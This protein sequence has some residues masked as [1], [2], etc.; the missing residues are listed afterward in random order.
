M[1]K[2]RSKIAVLAVVGMT[3]GVLPGVA[4]ENAFDGQCG[5]TGDGIDGSPWLLA[6]ES[7]LIQIEDCLVV[8]RTN[9]FELSQNIFIGSGYSNINRDSYLDDSDEDVHLDGK[10]YGIYG[11]KLIAPSELEVGLFGDLGDLTVKNLTIV[12]GAIVG[13]NETSVLVGEVDNLVVENVTITNDSLTCSDECG[14]LAARVVDSADVKNVSVT[15]GSFVVGDESGLLFGEVSTTTIT[16]DTVHAVGRYQ[17]R[18]FGTESDELSLGALIGMAGTSDITVNNAY[19]SL[20]PIEVD[21]NWRE[22]FMCVGGVVGYWVAY[23]SDPGN[24]LTLKGVSVNLDIKGARHFGGAVGCVYTDNDFGGPDPATAVS[25]DFDDISVMGKVWFG[26]FGFTGYA[27]GILGYSDILDKHVSTLDVKDAL[28]EVAYTHGY[29]LTDV[30][31]NS[32]GETDPNELA[33]AKWD[34]V[35]YTNVYLNSTVWNA[36]NAGDFQS[37][38]VDADG[39]DISTVQLADSANLAFDNMVAHPG[40]LGTD[41]WEHCAMGPRPVITPNYCSVATADLSSNQLTGTLGQAAGSITDS[42]PKGFGQSLF[43]TVEPTLPAGMYL[44]PLTGEVTG[45]P[46]ELR[47]AQTYRLRKYNAYTNQFLWEFDQGA[48]NSY[49]FVLET[50]VPVVR[51]VVGVPVPVKQPYAGPILARFSEHNLVAGEPKEITVSG[52]RLNLIQSVTAQG[53]NVEVVSQ[54]AELATLMIPG[55]EPGEVNLEVKSSEGVL[56]FLAFTVMEKE[57]IEIQETVVNAGSFKGYV[58]IYARGYEGKRLSAKV[59]KDWVVV[60]EIVNNA[61]NGTLFRAVEFTGAGYTLNIPI[62]IDRVLVRTV[63]LTTK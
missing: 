43:Y 17:L 5:L 10:G 55:L 47:S 32:I 48:P 18:D 24:T 28:I 27:G 6:T 57:P 35:N 45:T 39:N 16:I 53:K 56:D 63:T 50:K 26:S 13:G 29:N 40:Q 61:E 3:L 59:G 11:L 25:F 52:E 54:T 30:E 12:S 38:D 51:E 31:V 49:Y 15:T 19:I 8:G 41:D 33:S 9:Y 44:N 60:P 1:G 7:D 2:L 42:D 21:N 46:L 22:G 62:Y 4:A 36:A 23:D 37:F 14:L 20:E 34:T 58:A